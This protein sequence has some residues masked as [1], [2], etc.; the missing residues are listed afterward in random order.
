M[1]FRERKRGRERVSKKWGR[2]WIFGSKKGKK[3]LTTA[4]QSTTGSLWWALR[5]ALIFLGHVTTSYADEHSL[6]LMTLK[7]L[8]FDPF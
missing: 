2:R 6:P 1:G 7:I 5:A 3:P 8:T 4:T